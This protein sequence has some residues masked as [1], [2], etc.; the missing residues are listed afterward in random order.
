MTKLRWASR[1]LIG[2]LALLALA[3]LAAPS[4]GADSDK[5]VLADLISK[6]L[7]SQATQVRNW[8][9]SAIAS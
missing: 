5:G 2:A 4:L 6:A 7:S 3:W 8:F 9:L 1:G